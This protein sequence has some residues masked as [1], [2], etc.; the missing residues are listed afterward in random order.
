MGWL[1]ALLA[2]AGGNA[3][4]VDPAGRVVLELTHPFRDGTTHMLYSPEDWMARLADP[5]AHDLGR[6]V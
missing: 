3:C 6:A 2:L 5:R 4:A 1:R